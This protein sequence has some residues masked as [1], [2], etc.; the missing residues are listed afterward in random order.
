[1]P[2]IEPPVTHF[3]DPQRIEQH[4][5]RADHVADG[6]KGEFQPIGFAGRGRDLGRSRRSHASADD[7]GADDEEA[8]GIDRLSGA[9]HHVP[10]TGL[11]G[12]GLGTGDEL[13]HRQCMAD[14]HGVRSLRVHTAIRN[15]GDGER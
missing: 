6:D 10:P 1:M 14:E 7:I 13:I 2:P 3:L 15:V 5:L 4:R 9:D 11:A 12:H 8:V